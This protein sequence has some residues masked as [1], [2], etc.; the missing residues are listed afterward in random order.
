MRARKEEAKPL[1]AHL[2]SETQPCPPGFILGLYLRHR[3]LLNRKRQNIWF[4][5]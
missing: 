2:F 3:N 1:V 5:L 4:L